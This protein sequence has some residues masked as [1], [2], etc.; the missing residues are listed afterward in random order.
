MKIEIGGHTDNVGDD[1]AN[2]ILSKQR[3]DAVRDYLVENGISA[4]LLETKG[5]G[6][7]KP[8]A[9]NKTEEGRRKNR[10]VEIKFIKL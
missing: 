10:R 5:Y 7:S 4:D 8:I 1:N 9:S 6:E 2:L 3:A